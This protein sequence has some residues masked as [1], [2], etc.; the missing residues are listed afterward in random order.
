MGCRRLAYLRFYVRARFGPTKV[1]PYD[2][3][4]VLGGE[5]RGF[6][7]VLLLGMLLALPAAAQIRVEGLVLDRASSRPV[8]GA[9]VVRVGSNEGTVANGDGRFVLEV[10]RL[11]VSLRVS[12]I[13][14]AAATVRFERADRPGLVRRD[15]LLAPA[16]IEGSE[17]DVVAGEDPG[18]R[19]MRQ[20]VARRTALRRRTPPYTADGYTRATVL[21]QLPSS[22]ATRPVRLVEAFSLLFARPDGQRRED[23]TARRRV[24]SG[25]PFEH[26]DTEAVPDVYFEDVFRLDGY[27]TR[28]PLDPRNLGLYTYRLGADTLIDGRTMVD[29]AV[30]PTVPF[31]DA[32][33][34]RIR[35]VYG[36]LVVA[37]AEWR[38]PQPPPGAFVEFRSHYLVQYA[39][40]TDSL[41]LPSRFERRVRAWAGTPGNT[42][43]PFDTAQTTTVSAYDFTYGGP[44]AAFASSDRYHNPSDAYGGQEVFQRFR[45][46][47]PLADAERE[48]LDGLRGRT[49][50]GLVWREGLIARMG[51]VQLFDKLT[52]TTPGVGRDDPPRR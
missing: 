3:F 11:P 22:S 20:V 17:L 51:I 27:T 37:E 50:A 8:P 24:P 52:G 15:I 1:G 34:G 13:G 41:W 39:A 49:T 9:T 19:F 26:A 29:V 42:L 6:G 2:R 21:S 14:Y 16:D 5:L 35:V 46:D 44:D 32:F 36:L 45:D 31:P 33:T 23:V 7:A 40:A 18:L 43:P 12:S 28:S 38:P 30:Y 48:V 47:R 25:G 10:A 4:L